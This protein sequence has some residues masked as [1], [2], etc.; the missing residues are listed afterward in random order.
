MIKYVPEKIIGRFLNINRN[1]KLNKWYKDKNIFYL[2]R[3]DK[4][5][6]AKFKGKELIFKNKKIYFYR[7]YWDGYFINEKKIKINSEK[8]NNLIREYPEIKRLVIKE[9]PEYVI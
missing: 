8:Y 9:K 2:F 6:F 3:N 5:I 4:I 1:P 7:L